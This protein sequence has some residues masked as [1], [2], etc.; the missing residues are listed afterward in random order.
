M[1]LENRVVIVTGSGRNIG[2][3]IARAL[4]VEGASVVVVDKL[5][6]RATSVSD[7]INADA[8]KEGREGMALPI[9]CDV[10]NSADVQAMVAKVVDAL[11]DIYALVNNVGVVDRNNILE[12]D[13]AEWDRVIAISLKSVFLVSKAVARRLVDQ[14]KG[15]RI[16]NIGSTSGLSGRIGATAYPS[17]KSGVYNLS[18]SM[19][20]QLGPHGIRVNTVTPNRVLT[21]AGPGEPSRV[22]QVTNLVGR[23]GT[24]K[25]IASAVVFLA[26]DEADFIT[27]TDITVDGGVRA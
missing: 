10:T 4:A 16:I 22:W 21:V 8:A 24:P 27:G 19:A 12:T 2:E 23:Q 18:R 20:I 11:G 25:D 14:G 17:A 5:P 9:G 7:S 6:E 3:G 26:S 1:R 15:G 13:E